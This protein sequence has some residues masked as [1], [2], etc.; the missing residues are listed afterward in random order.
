VLSQ[1]SFKT[2]T[3]SGKGGYGFGVAVTTEDGM[4][5]VDHNGAIE[6]F[7]AHLAYVPEPRIAVIVLSNVFG[8]APPAM[9]NQLVEAMLGKTVV[10]ARER[11]VVPISSED[12]ARFA[13]TYQMSSGMTFTFTTRG[14]S[15]VLLCYKN[16]APQKGQPGSCRSR[17]RAM[18]CRRVAM[19]RGLCR[20]PR[21]GRPPRMELRGHFGEG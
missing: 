21:T 5:V 12:L 19:D 14:D 4:K 7:V 17:T 1:S 20:S 13:C 10:L 3:T 6:G 16:G 18:V 9:G 2:M 15:L 8:G 11:K